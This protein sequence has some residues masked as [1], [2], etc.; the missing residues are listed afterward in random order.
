MENPTK[1]THLLIFATIIVSCLVCLSSAKPNSASEGFSY[2]PCSERGP[3]HW[4]DLEEQWAKC[5]NGKM[6]SPVA[7]SLWNATFNGYLGQLRRN[8][9]PAIAILE[10]NGHQVVVEWIENAGSIKINGVNYYLQDYHWHHPSEH[11]QDGK[12]YPLELHMVHTNNNPNVTNKIAVI[13]IL[14]KFGPPDPFLRL[15]EGDIKRL[16]IEGGER[17][18]GTVDPRLA[19]PMYSWSETYFR[20]M[21]SLTTPPCTEGVI[22]TVMKKIQT[23]SPYQVELLKQAVVE[24]KNARS[25]QNINRREIF[26]FGP[27]LGRKSAA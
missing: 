21:G 17:W 11:T 16:N 10:N 20:Y 3:Q 7:L 9:W 8:H 25:L 6:Q 12:T 26:Y 14:Y 13:S 1:K 22:W 24:E 27:L 4:G 2:D 5:K 23:V 15:I 18:L 19:W